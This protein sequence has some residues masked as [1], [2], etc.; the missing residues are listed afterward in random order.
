VA[1][2]LVA[3]RGGATADLDIV[4]PYRR[5]PE[6]ARSCALI[7]DTIV[8][9]LLARLAPAQVDPAVGGPAEAR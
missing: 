2:A 4:D 8:E 7:L 9:R 3:A 6:A 1:A 5:G